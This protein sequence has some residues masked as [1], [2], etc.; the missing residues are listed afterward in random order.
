MVGR[1]DVDETLWGEAGAVSGTKARVG[2]YRWIICVLLFLAT[3]INYLDRQVLGILAAPLQEQLGWSESDYGWIT[4]AFTGA[5]AAG[6]LIVGRL[7]DLLGTRMG[8]GL[9]VVCWSL[10]AMGHALARS[11]LGF[12]VARFALGLSES[13]NFPAAIKTVAEWYP[14]SERAF[15]TGLFNSGSNVGAIVAPL[16][17]PWIATR[18]GWR[19][20]FVVTG[21][22]G[23]AW[24]AAWLAIYR[25]PE[26]HPQLSRAELA[27]IRSD[28]VEPM[29]RIPWSRLLRHRQTWAFAAGKFFTDPIWWFFLFWLPK[30]LNHRYGISLIGLGPPL[31]VVYLAADLGSIGGGWIS[32]T[33]IHRGWS[34][35]AGRKTAM[36]AAA[37][38]VVPILLAARTSSL[39]VAVALISLAT[40]AHQGWS[41]N[42]FTLVSDMFPRPAV[43]SVV[44]IG[45]FAGSVSGMMIAAATGY[46]LEWTGSYVPVF[47]VAA[48][49]YL[50]ALATIHLLVPD[51][52]A[53]RLQQ[54]H[55][56]AHAG[57][58]GSRGCGPGPERPRGATS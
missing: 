45:G 36:L 2:G 40:A 46:L 56:Q 41:A 43:A 5:Y 57:S 31:V 58:A 44:G 30:F 4:T 53:V 54:D 7:M 47:F 8:F 10:A 38:C 20:A 42:L 9:A 6:Q 33:L 50:I 27:H 18:Y 15:A 32:S 26:E 13:G 48:S 1:S 52:R 14:K 17:V 21:L 24:L 16:V 39:W 28:P 29:D 35:N 11:A 12:G 55:G 49:A 22:T 34:V 51:L 23:F 19:W 37:L 25:R 3:T